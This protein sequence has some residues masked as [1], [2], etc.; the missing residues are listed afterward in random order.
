MRNRCDISNTRNV[1]TRGLKRTYGRLPSTPWAAY[2]NVYLAQSVLHT[3]PCG[4]FRRSLGGVCSS[5]ARSLESGRPCAPPGQDI[6]LGISQG[7]DGIVECR[8][9]ISPPTWD[10]FTFSSLESRWLSFGHESPPLT[11]WTYRGVCLCRQ[12]SSGNL[13]W[14]AHS[15]A[16]FDREPAIR[17]GA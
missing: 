6:A 3:T 8:L 12:P 5:L 11:F 15:Y 14:F 13:S 7:D 1:K 17:G 4:G 10:C 9:D 16:F 2:V